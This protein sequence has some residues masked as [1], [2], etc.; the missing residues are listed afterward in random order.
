[1]KSAKIIIKNEV[2]CKIDGLDVE[3]RRKLNKK[4]EF[5]KPGARYLTSVKYG[6]WNGKVSYC[7]ISGST[8]VNLLEE[9]VPILE[10]DGYHLE[11]EDKRDHTIK[12]EFEEVTKDSFNDVLWP[13]GHVLAGT[14]VVPKDHQLQIING[15]L[16][17]PQSIYLAATSS[18]KTLVTAALSKS[19]E[20][21]GKS[22]VIV[23]NKSLVVQTEV[24]YVNMGLDVGVYFGDRKEL[25]KTHT[26][27]TWQSLNAIL[28]ARQENPADTRLD[29][30]LDVICVICD[31]THLCKAEVLRKLLNETFAHVP[32]R[33]GLTGT[34]PKDPMDQMA[35]FV[36]IGPVIGQVA[37]KDLQEIGILA[38]CHVNIV[39]LKDNISL[40]NYQSEL[41]YLLE[42]EKRLDKMAQLIKRVAADTGNTLVLVDRI[43]AGKELAKRLDDAVFINGSVSTTDRSS[44]FKEINEDD[45]RITI[46]TYAVASTGIS[47][48]RL[49][50]LVMIEPG[51]S[52]VRTIQSI[53]R[54]LRVAP[55]KDFAN[56]WDITS[57]C[58]YSKKHL[59]ERKKYYTESNYPFEIEKLEYK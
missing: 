9:I 52:Y 38:K 16:Q 37:A 7:T 24:D 47:I 14:P 57:N 48:N 26:I 23:P 36:S 44:E 43:N 27:C 3:T 53:G 19:V 54:V 32:L 17:N 20:K 29:N 31:E 34:M 18:G 22:L 51:K 4:F 45:N 5:E 33:W 28:K 13:E 2:Q 58:K 35:L 12:F 40:P 6:R 25:G 55:D 11:L 42:D 50:N 10:Q 15:C 49:F 46:A 30:F 8:Y 41:K 56:I 1:M 39:Q 59:T 21:Y